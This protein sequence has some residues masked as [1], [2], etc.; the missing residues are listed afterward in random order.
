MISDYFVN[1][2]SKWYNETNVSR[3]GETMSNIDELYHSIV[4]QENTQDVEDILHDLMEQVYNTPA[5]AS[6][7]LELAELFMANGYVDYHLSLLHHLWQVMPSSDISQILAQTYFD[8]NE[9]SMAFYWIKES[10]AL[11]EVSTTLLEIKILMSMNQN[12]KAVTLLKKMITTQP[13]VVEAYYLLALIYY[14][15]QDFFSARKYLNVIIEYFPESEW[16]TLAR[17]RLLDIFELGEIYALEEVSRLIDHPDLPP[18]T[19]V[20]EFQSV[21]RI[22]FQSQQYEQAYEFAEKVCHC[23]A[24]AFE[25]IVMQ[26]VILAEQNNQH[27]FEEKMEWLIHNV[28]Y[29]HDLLKEVFELAY[30]LKYENTELALRFEELLEVAPSHEMQYQIIVYAVLLIEDVSVQKRLHA[31]LCENEILSGMMD[32]DKAIIALNKWQYTQEVND[33]MAFY[34]ILEELEDISLFEHTILHLHD[35]I[36]TLEGI[37]QDTRGLIK[38]YSKQLVKRLEG[39]QYD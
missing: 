38:Q 14:F 18:L 39:E 4:T 6:V 25:M 27:L 10:K 9:F 34:Q 23:D 3:E 20:E 17:L 22:Y 28:P 37:L 31:L 7:L 13:E 12:Q 29:A 8:L 36:D 33:L 11:G 26:A 1:Y 2:T 5:Y 32:W 30:R 19:H 35:V 21:A 24:D 16:S 15:E